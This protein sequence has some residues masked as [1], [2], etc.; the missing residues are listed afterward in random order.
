MKFSLCSLNSSPEASQ[1]GFHNLWQKL[2]P[3]TVDSKGRLVY[4][5]S[6]F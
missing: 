5:H 6:Q 1:Q 4:N 2:S 3:S